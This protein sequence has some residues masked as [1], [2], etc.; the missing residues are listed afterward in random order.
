VAALG[1][2]LGIF[3]RGGLQ[4]DRLEHDRGITNNDAIDVL[5]ELVAMRVCP[6]MIRVTVSPS[7][8]AA[9]AASST[10]LGVRSRWM[11]SAPC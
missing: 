8:A 1:S 2:K 4:G 10:L 6:K 11:L 7:P 9:G 3:E 5:A